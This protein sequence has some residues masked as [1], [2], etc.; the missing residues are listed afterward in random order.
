MT[1]Q[2]YETNQLRPMHAYSFVDVVSHLE[3]SADSNFVMIGVQK[4][5]LVFV[6][7]LHDPEW[8]C[9][10]DEGV[11]GLA[12]CQWGPGASHVMTV[13]EFKVRLSVWC[14]A[15]KSVQFIRSPKFDDGRGVAFSPNKKLMA[16]AEKSL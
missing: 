3:W 14:L 12:F 2:I 1:P 15:D 16:L 10:I 8:Q 5:A 13:S 6:K 4:R 11:A 7:S 9:K